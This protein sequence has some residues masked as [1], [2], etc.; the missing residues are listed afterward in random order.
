MRRLVPWILVALVALGAAAGAT[1]G[2]ARGSAPEKPSQWVAAALAATERAG[3]A[4]FSYTSVTSSPNADLRSSVSGAGEVN[5]ATGDVQVTE[6]DHEVSY[7]SSGN[8]PMHP[9]HSSTTVKAIV[10]GGTVYQA[11]PIPGF[12]FTAQ[13]HVLPFPKLPRAQRG[14]ALALDADVALAS[15]RGPNAVASVINL[16]PASI[17]GAATTRHEVTFAS[18]RACAP[19]QAPVVVNQRP[20]DVWVDGSG[21]LRQ[22]RSTSYVSDRLPRNEKVPAAFGGFPRAPMTTVSTL[23]FSAFGIPVHVVAPSASALAPHGESSAGL[24]IAGAQRC[25]S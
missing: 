13:Y 4:R 24:V 8:Q 10:I 7:V 22:V 11:N 19:H 25:P 23:A 21:R 9:V 15:L 14:L 6:V 18:F 16:G 20:T 17:D 1:L 12:R 2:I 3:T 5:F